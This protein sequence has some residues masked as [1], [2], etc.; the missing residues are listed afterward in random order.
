MLSPCRHGLHT[1]TFS[2]LHGTYG[3][4]TRPL[5]ADLDVQLSGLPCSYLMRRTDLAIPPRAAGQ[6][7]H[8]SRAHLYTAHLLPS[9]PI[10]GSP[11]VLEPRCAEVADQARIGA[12]MR[13]TNMFPAKERVSGMETPPFARCR[14]LTCVDEGVCEGKRIWLAAAKAELGDRARHFPNAGDQNGGHLVPL[15]QPSAVI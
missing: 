14:K 12:E 3:P 6:Y 5:H 4:H 8:I 15:T 7:R 11:R 2:H 13:G 1:V 10:H 9:L